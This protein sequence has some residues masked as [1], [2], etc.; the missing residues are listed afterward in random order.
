MALQEFCP[1]TSSTPLCGQIWILMVKG[2]C[3]HAPPITP[4]SFHDM[5]AQM[6]Q[7]RLYML[8]MQLREEQEE[9]RLRHGDE[10]GPKAMSAMPYALSTVKEILRILPALPAIWRYPVSWK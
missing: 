2:L 10:L 3:N 8:S 9:V 4:I 1:G 5:R 6:A 7:T